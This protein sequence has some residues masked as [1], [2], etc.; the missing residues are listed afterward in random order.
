MQQ[1]G[2]K[3]PAAAAELF[4]Q[5]IRR[6]PNIAFPEMPQVLRPSNA[7]R[8]TLISAM[9]A[10]VQVRADHSGP[11]NRRQCSELTPSSLESTCSA[12]LGEGCT[13]DDILN[14]LRTLA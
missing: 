12:A 4:N 5:Q 10:G 1:D 3:L 7:Y 2:V 13:L 6:L 11:T 8:A 14:P 9:N